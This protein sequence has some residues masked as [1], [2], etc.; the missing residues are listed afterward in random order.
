MR[1]AR[2]ILDWTFAGDIRLAVGDL[3]DD[4]AVPDRAFE[5]YPRN[6]LARSMATQRVLERLPERPA[7]VLK[8]M[9]SLGFQR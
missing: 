2:S 6:E 3:A 1:S 9:R 5:W 7:D 4:P 8:L